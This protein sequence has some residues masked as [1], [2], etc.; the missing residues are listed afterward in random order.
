[1]LRT[2]VVSVCAYVC[3]YAADDDLVLGKSDPFVVFS[4]NGQRVYKSQTKK[5]TVNPDWH[6]QFIVQVV[7]DYPKCSIVVTLTRG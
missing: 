4:L 5:K 7:R 2:G 3:A 1:M 6:E